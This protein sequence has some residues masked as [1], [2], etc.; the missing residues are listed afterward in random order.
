MGL[1]MISRRLFPSGLPL[2]K[3]SSW[4]PGAATT[5]KVG[6]GMYS[7][8][9][10]FRAILVRPLTST[11]WTSPAYSAGRYLVKASVVSYMWLSASKTGKSITRAM[12]MLLLLSGDRLGPPGPDG[13]ALVASSA[14]RRFSTQAN[15]P[16]CQVEMTF[17]LPSHRSGGGTPRV[18]GRRLGDEGVTTAPA[19]NDAVPY[20]TRLGQLAEEL[21]DATAVTFVDVD[22]V[23]QAVSWRQLDT[24]STQLAHV[25]AERGLGVGDRLAVGLPN[26]LEHL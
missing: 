22:G 4:A 20:G 6:L 23:E 2:R 12:V 11:Y 14:I 15:S 3:Y 25:L 19:G 26:S 16:Q 24:R 7:L 18:G 10:P 9:W 13:V 1:P 5:E 21:G 17:A 8:I